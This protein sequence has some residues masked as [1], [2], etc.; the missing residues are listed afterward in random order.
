[1]LLPWFVSERAES[2]SIGID[3][4]HLDGMPN[5]VMRTHNVFS[6]LISPNG[7]LNYVM[8]TSTVLA[9]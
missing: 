5:Y 6:M 9:C 3:R 4:Q 8:F 1:M 7:M 2:V